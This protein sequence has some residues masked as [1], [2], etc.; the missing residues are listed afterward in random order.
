M[1]IERIMMIRP[2]KRVPRMA[3]A[4][5]IGLLYIISVLREKYPGRFQFELVEQA[6]YN[7]STED[8]R[9][10]FREFSPD[11]VAFSAMSVDGNELMELSRMVKEEKP[12]CLAI[13]GGPYASSFNDWI[14]S[15]DIVV[16]GEGES[17]FPELLDNL[18]ADEPLD[19]VKGIAFKKNEQIVRTE[20]REFIENLDLIPFPAWDLIEFDKYSVELSMNYY[21]H[22]TPWAI[23]FTS[24]A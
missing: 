5:P 15:V 8:V 11:L 6:I 16:Q 7:L 1:K 19:S 10:R 22:S 21:C 24:R 9:L 18:I 23:M 4:Q 2:G 12:G 20:P 3:F 13:V 17:T 14:A